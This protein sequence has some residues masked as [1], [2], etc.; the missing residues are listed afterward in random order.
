[1]YDIYIT[2]GQPG[3]HAGVRGN[4]PRADVLDEFSDFP[5]PRTHSGHACDR[6]GQPG[7]HAGV[8][9]NSPVRMWTSFCTS[10]M[11]SIRWPDLR[12]RG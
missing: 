8:I 7:K 4:S 10:S 1:M 9:G 12:P 2:S 5:G 6:S 3:K 11:L